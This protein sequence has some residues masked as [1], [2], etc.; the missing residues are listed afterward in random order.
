MNRLCFYMPVKNQIPVL[1]D[2]DGVI[3]I[4]TEN[5]IEAAQQIGGKGILVFT[6]K[7]K[8]PLPG[9]ANIHPHYT[10][11]NLTEVIELLKRF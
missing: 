6:G 8:H 10:A 2:F 7:T 9:T 11:E 3:K 1:I 5:D 4:G